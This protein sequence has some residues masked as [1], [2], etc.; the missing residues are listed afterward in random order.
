MVA[1]TMRSWIHVAVAILAAA[2]AGRSLAQPSL[3]ELTEQTCER[4]TKV[5]TDTGASLASTADTAV[6][7]IH[8]LDAQG[9]SNATILHYYLEMR[10]VL[11]RTGSGGR[12][13]VARIQTNAVSTLTRLNAPPEL[14]AQVND[15]SLKASRSVGVKQSAAIEQVRRAVVAA[16]R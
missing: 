12:T 4:L 6:K 5:E 9:A 1:G 2:F 7:E 13:L 15:H 11:T 10:M 14:I 8:R 16:T 3:L